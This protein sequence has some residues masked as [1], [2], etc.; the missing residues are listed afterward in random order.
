[1]ADQPLL[2]AVQRDV[3]DG[4]PL[5]DVLRKCILLGSVSGSAELRAWATKELKGYDD[6]AELPDYRRVSAQICADAV[7]GNSWVQRQ[8]IGLSMLPEWAREHIDNR[9]PLFGGVGELQS[10]YDGARASGKNPQ[11]SLPGWEVIAAEMDR[12]SPNPFQHIHAL[13]WVI[14]PSGIAGVLDAVKTAL[15]EILAEL[16]ATMPADQDTPTADQVTNAL[17][18]AISGGSPQFNIAAPTTSIN[19][20]GSASVEGVTGGQT[21]VAGRDLTQTATYSITHNE[22]VRAWLDEYRAALPEVNEALRPV[23]E[24]QL[25]QVGAEIAKDE[26]QEIVVN[27]LMNSLRTFAQN[28]IASAGAGAGTIGLT[29]VLAHWPF[30]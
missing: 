29:E 30:H 17:H 5:A 1:M 26:P 19:A 3:L 28:A 9:V 21:G 22:A 13:Y 18:V 16:G 24:Q 7:T 15:T 8:S 12:V 23:I 11:T 14:S 25:D 6:A 20:S 27:T 4:K 2:A 10:L